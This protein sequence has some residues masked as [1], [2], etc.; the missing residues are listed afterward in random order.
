MATVCANESRFDSYRRCIDDAWYRGVA[1]A[2][3]ASDSYVLSF[4]SRMRLLGRAVETG[5]MS[6]TAAIMNAMNFAQ[7]LRGAEQAEISRQNDAFA[8]ALSRA[9]SESERA[10]SNYPSRSAPTIVMCTKIGDRSNQ[11]YSFYAIACPLGYA[12]AL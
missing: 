2:G 1:A 7:Q 4:S 5:E 8:Q 6:D 9:A 3:Y 12:S 11:V 10:Q